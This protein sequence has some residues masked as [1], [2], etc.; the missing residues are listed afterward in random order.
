MLSNAECIHV[1]ENRKKV[2]E[3]LLLRHLLEC[4]YKDGVINTLTFLEAQKG[5]ESYDTTTILK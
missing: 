3:K 4:M 2:N 5:V 1:L